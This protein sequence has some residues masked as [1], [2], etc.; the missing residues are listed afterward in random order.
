[1]AHFTFTIE[2]TTKSRTFKGGG[3]RWRWG[4]NHRG[5]GTGVPQRVQGRS[6]GRGSEGR[7]PP[8]LKNFKSSYK[9]FY[10]FLVV[11][12]TFSPI[13]AYVFSVLAGIIPLSLQN[14]GGSFDTVC[15]PPLVC[16]WGNSP[17]AP[18]SRRLCELCF[19]YLGGNPAL[20]QF[21]L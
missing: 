1:M 19:W 18:G 15:P 3:R 4:Q 9:Q 21:L 11:F 2:V 16:K 13:Y 14:G 5:S 20:C 12:H 10:A 8:K 17:S 6:P 7:S